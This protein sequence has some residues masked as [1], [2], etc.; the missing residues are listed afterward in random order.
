MAMRLCSSIILSNLI[1][2]FL[3]L[4]ALAT[5][6][7]SFTHTITTT[8]TTKLS[9]FTCMSK[10]LVGSSSS[11]MWGCSKQMAVNTTR[12]FCPP[13]SLQ[14][15]VRWCWPLRPKRPSIAR[16]TVEGAMKTQHPREQRGR[17]WAHSERRMVLKLHQIIK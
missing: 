9:S 8:T 12:D 2:Y 3:L 6:N 1:I 17:G 10:W 11:R 16:I 7:S 13:L 14:M 5:P 4:P 15:G